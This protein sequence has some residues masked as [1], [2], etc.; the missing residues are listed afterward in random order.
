MA[1]LSEH[2]ADCQKLL[3]QPFE[4]VHAFLDQFFPI[5]GLGH[6]RLLHHQRGVELIVKK[7]GEAARSAA[8]LHIL[9]DLAP[10]NELGQDWQEL[11]NIIPQSWDGYG[12]PV[13]LDLNLY[14]QLDQD[15]VTLYMD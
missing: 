5:Y 11:R 14:D 2:C 15:I 1:Y 3:G 10:K 7:F 4:E 8:E 9:R 13:L 6:R 12:E